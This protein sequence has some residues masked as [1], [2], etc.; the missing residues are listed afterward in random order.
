[1]FKLYSSNGDSSNGDLDMEFLKKDYYYFIES[2]DA[3]VVD[4]A[5]VKEF[6]EKF[7][8]FGVTEPGIWVNSVSLGIGD[9]DDAYHFIQIET[10]KNI[11]NTIMKRIQKLDD[12]LNGRSDNGTVAT[13]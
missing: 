1:M 2:V 13:F 4:D 7:G 3:I 12:V 5:G 9:M 11:T 10:A 6:R 8:N